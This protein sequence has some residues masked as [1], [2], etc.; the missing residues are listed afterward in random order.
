MTR[1]VIAIRS[2]YSKSCSRHAT[3]CKPH[4]KYNH[5]RLTLC[6]KFYVKRN[7]KGTQTQSYNIM[8]FLFHQ[9][10]YSNSRIV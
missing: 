3:D 8:L 5:T 1:K 7:N 10:S 6:D 2:A 9:L 4:G